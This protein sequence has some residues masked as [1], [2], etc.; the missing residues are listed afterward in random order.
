MLVTYAEFAVSCAVFASVAALVAVS[1]AACESDIADTA[2]TSAL[3]A[4]VPADCAREKA[5]PAEIIAVFAVLAA[6]LATLTADTDVL[7]AVP[8]SAICPD[9]IAG[10]TDS[11]T[12]I[13]LIYQVNSTTVG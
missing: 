8:I 2:L 5:L 7:T 1:T 10:V 12:F 13:S 4:D 11:E 6:P 3:I 9:V